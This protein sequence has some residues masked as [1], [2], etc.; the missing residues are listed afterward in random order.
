MRALLGTIGGA[1]FCATVAVTVLGLLTAIPLVT[2]SVH[3]MDRE[4]HL[5]LI[6]AICAIS[7]VHGFILGALAGFA[8]R[9]PKHGAPFLRCCILIAVPVGI[10][11][12]LTAPQPKLYT[13]D[14]SYLSCLGTAILAT[15]ILVCWGLRRGRT[16]VKKQVVT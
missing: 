15:A 4:Q 16:A 8:S 13:S 1:L 14:V 7:G 10:V 11:R 2:G 12:V 3:P 6:A 5:G 9:F